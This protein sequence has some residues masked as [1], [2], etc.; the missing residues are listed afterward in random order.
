MKDLGIKIGTKEEAFW[1]EVKEQT[2]RDIERLERLLVLQ[3]AILEMSIKKIELI[4]L[5]P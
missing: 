4:N 5:K 3:K 1:T 2:E